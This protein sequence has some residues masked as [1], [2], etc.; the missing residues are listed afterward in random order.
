MRFGDE[1]NE[2]RGVTLDSFLFDDGW[3][4]HDEL[5]TIRTDFKNG[6]MPLKEAA[7]QYGTAPGVW[8]SPWG[9]YGKPKQERIAA[10]KREGYE[11]VNGGFALSGPKYYARFHEVVHGDGHEVWREPVQVRR[12]RQCRSGGEGQPSSTATSMR[13]FT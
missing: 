5:W 1:L 6:F 11:I 9:G 10:G 8:L 3:D 12:H 13:R 2:K 7:A 4:D